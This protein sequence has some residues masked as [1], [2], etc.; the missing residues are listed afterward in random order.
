MSVAMKTAPSISPPENSMKSGD[1]VAR[2]VDGVQH[3]AESAATVPR[4]ATGIRQFIMLR[5]TR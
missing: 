4:I 1:G 2:R 5:A 3:A